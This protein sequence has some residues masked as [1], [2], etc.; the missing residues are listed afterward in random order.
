MNENGINIFGLVQALNEC[1]HFRNLLEQ[2]CKRLQQREQELMAQIQQPENK[3]LE[4]V[5]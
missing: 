4:A 1:W 2:E 5:S 3:K